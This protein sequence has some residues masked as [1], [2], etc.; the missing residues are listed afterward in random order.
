MH[1]IEL[2]LQ[3]PAARRGAVDAAV[4]GRGGEPRVRLRAAYYDTT[5]RRLARAGLA[6]RLRREGRRWVQT[7]KGATDDGITRLEHNVARGSAGPMP[8]LA[9]ALHAGTP[10]G[11]RLHALLGTPPEP[12]IERY[13]TDI[14][15]RRRVL[16]TLHGRIELGFDVGTIQAGDALQDVLELEIELVAGS[17]LAVLET[18]TR[19]ITRYGLWLDTRSKAERGD[20]LADNGRAQ[21]APRL[22][23]DPTLARGTTAAAAWQAVL[24]ACSEQIIANASQIASGAHAPEHVHQL[25]V[26]LRRLRSALQLFDGLG[27]DAELAVPA[28]L[29]F[30]R[31]GRSRD[32]LVIADEFGA[33]LRGALRSAGLDGATPLPAAARDEPAPTDALRE[34]GSQALL[35]QL[36]AAA[37]AGGAA[38][39]RAVAEGDAIDLRTAIARRLTRWHRALVA[40]A[41]RFAELDDA[42]RHRLRKRA[43]RLRYA[44]EFCGA[45]FEG[46]ARRRY[47]RALC[48]LQERLSVF[49]D[50][51]MA[52]QA[53]AD[54][55]QTGEGDNLRSMFAL[56]WLAARREQSI[57]AAAPQLGAFVK[58]E[59]FWK[60]KRRAKSAKSPK[61]AKGAKSTSGRSGP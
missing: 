20:L 51:T 16:R 3:V 19:W 14:L 15:R 52:M 41:A 10:A 60:T 6:L 23:R 7:L 5:D 24:R 18:A 40:D 9:A 44:T 43:K 31:L 13:R 45:L 61:G 27:A 12:L 37:Q 11:E 46:H 38:D 59:R 33:G 48:A 58:V 4:A 36:L 47:L 49:S 54:D 56:G 39:K 50:A 26:G 28:A 1:E 21:A 8:A 55:L 17:P 2:K 32:R 34:P 35:L 57:A 30:R 42:R 25:R 22:A 29:L 53:F